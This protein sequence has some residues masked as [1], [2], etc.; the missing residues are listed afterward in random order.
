M[1]AGREVIPDDVVD[2][3]THAF[4][5]ESSFTLRERHTWFGRV[6]AAGKPGEDLHVHEAPATVFGVA[7]VQA[8]YALTLWTGRGI[9]AGIGGTASISIVPSALTSRYPGRIAP[10]FGVFFNVRPSRHVM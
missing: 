4:L 1:N 8:G 6:E 10:G 3:V 5:V 7:K 9:V 2:L